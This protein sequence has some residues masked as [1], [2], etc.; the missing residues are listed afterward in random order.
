[1]Q[2]KKLQRQLQDEIDLHMA[3]ADA[4]T[5]NAAVILHSSIKVPDKVQTLVLF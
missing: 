4:I 5:H 2:V 1:M 3:L